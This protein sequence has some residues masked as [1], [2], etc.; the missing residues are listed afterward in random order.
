[1]DVSVA[2]VPA[3][4]VSME[5][6]SMHNDTCLIAM[7]PK[8]GVELESAP[9][10]PY[11]RRWNGMLEQKMRYEFLVR[12]VNTEN[13]QVG[14]LLYKELKALGS[15]EVAVVDQKEVDI[16]EGVTFTKLG[17]AIDVETEAMMVVTVLDSTK[18]LKSYLDTVYDGMKKFYIDEVL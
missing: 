2:G 14:K 11:E 12:W 1:M 6:N 8:E 7:K 4:N 5:W 9:K 3:K 16:P 17:D 10:F 13:R 15:V 18:D